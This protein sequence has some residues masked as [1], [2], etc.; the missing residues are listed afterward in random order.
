M[1]APT[2]Q[3]ACGCDLS[4]PVG[5]RAGRI[6]ATQACYERAK[7]ARIAVT[8]AEIAAVRAERREHSAGRQMCLG[9]E[10]RTWVRG[11][12]CSDECK[13]RHGAVDTAASHAWDG[14]GTLAAIVTD[15]RH[16]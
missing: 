1:S 6:Y 3:C 2:R 7:R 15:G 14:S 5:N 11:L 8:N 10:C 12:Y 13:A 16:G 9:P 4:F